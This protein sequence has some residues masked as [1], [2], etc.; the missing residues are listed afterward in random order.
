[1]RSVIDVEVKT[2]ARET[3]NLFDFEAKESAITSQS[4]NILDSVTFVRDANGKESAINVVSH[5][6]PTSELGEEG[7]KLIQLE[8]R[9][10]SFILNR[11]RWGTTDDRRIQRCWQLIRSSE[12]TVAM[13][14]RLTVHDII[15]FGRSQFKVRQLAV[16]AQGVAL[17]DGSA[18]CKVDPAEFGCQVG[19]QCR[20]CLSEGS[21]VEDPLLA[22]CKCRGSV[23]HVHLECVKHWI[24]DRL[25]L[26]NSGT[27]SMVGRASGPLSCELC[28]SPYQTTVQIGHKIV[29]LVKIDSPFIVLESCNDHRLHVLPITGEKPLKIGRSH[30]CNMNIH[31][32]S[33]SRVQASIELT[34]GGFHLKDRGSRFGT[35]I[36][37]TKPLVL[38]AGKQFSVQVGRSILQLN[39]KLA[40]SEAEDESL[41]Q[42]L[43]PLLSSQGEEASETELSESTTA[44]GNC[45]LRQGSGRSSSNLEHSH[46]S[47][48][49]EEEWM[50]WMD[51]VCFRLELAP[52]S[53]GFLRN[54][55]A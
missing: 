53:R 21:T 24:T 31:D 41:Q 34:D 55:N 36:K 32:T 54:N 11:P 50:Q 51:A 27:S 52:I 38:E 7:E 2:W 19:K 14:H 4:F 16:R 23:Q 22:P 47:P 35:Y 46:S 30:E 20:I 13:G 29:P 39:T 49:Q 12:D 3:H 5:S 1:M 37:I 6:S 8:W 9:H 18:I 45:L 15:K 25:A 40:S 43:K 44:S 26:S 10:G 48:W 17:D 28:K 33:I 42:I